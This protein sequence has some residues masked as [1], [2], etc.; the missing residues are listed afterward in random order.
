MRRFII[1]DFTDS[2][3]LFDNHYIEAETPIKAAKKYVN[4]RP[5]TKVTA[6]ERR[7][8]IIVQEVSERNRLLPHKHM[9]CYCIIK[10]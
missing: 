8:D 3:S 9:N 6:E 10:S 5:I 2:Y 4:N 7:P 1:D